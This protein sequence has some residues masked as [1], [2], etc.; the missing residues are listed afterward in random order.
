[1]K[2]DHKDIGRFCGSSIPRPFTT[3]A[4]TLFIRFHSDIVISGRGF[5]T[6]YSQAKGTRTYLCPS[7]YIKYTTV[8]IK[9]LG[10]TQKELNQVTDNYAGDSAL[11]TCKT[12]LSP[13]VTLCY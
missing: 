9:P 13:P 7:F 8:I 1:M 10:K 6:I 11:G 4:N 5:K 3:E 12:G 2:E